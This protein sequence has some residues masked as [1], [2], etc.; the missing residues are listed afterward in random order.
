[1][2]LFLPW[3]QVTDLPS[4]KDNRL[5][6]DPQF[7]ALG[8]D[9]RPAEKQQRQRHDE[10]A[11]PRGR[12]KVRRRGSARV[13]R[14]SNKNRRIVDVRAAAVPEPRERTA[15]TR[16]PFHLY[17]RRRLVRLQLREREPSNHPQVARGTHSRN[18]ETS[19]RQHCSTASSRLRLRRRGGAVPVGPPLRRQRAVVRI[20]RPVLGRH[21]EAARGGPRGRHDYLD[22][23][24]LWVA[25]RLCGINPGPRIDET[26]FDINRPLHGMHV[27]GRP[28]ATDADRRYWC[29]RVAPIVG[30]LPNEIAG[31]RYR[32]QTG[33]ASCRKS[34]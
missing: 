11:L 16:L 14:L 24:A 33:I 19:V 2:S 12:G 10:V 1:M 22:E 7:V 17:H 18:H 26:D 28:F 31:P 6:V 9:V 21:L 15:R 27:H 4:C 8:G 32:Q 13:G 25:S 29:S 3:R 34:R 5:H 20:R 23:H 30:E